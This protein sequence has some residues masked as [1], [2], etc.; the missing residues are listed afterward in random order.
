ME[1]GLLFFFLIWEEQAPLR[2]SLRGHSSSGSPEAEHTFL[3]F[4]LLQN[5]MLALLMAR[6]G[7]SYRAD[8]GAPWST[9]R[10]KEGYHTGGAACGWWGRQHWQEG[11]T[12]VEVWGSD[13]LLLSY[14]GWSWQPPLGE[15]WVGSRWRQQWHLAVRFCHWLDIPRPDFQA[16]VHG[17][18]KMNIS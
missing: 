6:R 17:T 7:S 14:A 11:E 18:F 4:S 16:V 9:Q 13:V 10:R 8:L 15:P 12:D 5:L 1:N 2:A 3:A